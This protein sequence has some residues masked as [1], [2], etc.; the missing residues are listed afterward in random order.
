M[1]Q[2]KSDGTTLRINRDS[3]IHSV[4]VVDSEKLNFWILLNRYYFFWY[5]NEPKY[6]QVPYLHK[7]KRLKTLK[8]DQ[9]HKY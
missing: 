5:S 3:E 7:S 9:N 4:Q 6:D 8:L 1:L 2:K